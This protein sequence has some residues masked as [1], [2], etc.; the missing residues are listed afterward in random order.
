MNQ[1]NIGNNIQYNQQNHMRLMFAF[2]EKLTTI[3]LSSS[4]NTKKILIF[5]IL[6]NNYK[7]LIFLHLTQKM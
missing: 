2:C 4:F 7:I 3:D 6:I 1:I 5:L